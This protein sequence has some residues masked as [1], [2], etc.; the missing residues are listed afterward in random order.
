MYIVGIA[1]IV[2]GLVVTRF[3]FKLSNAINRH[4][5]GQTIGEVP[6]DPR[7][8]LVWSIGG[9]VCGWGGLA[10]IGFGIYLLLT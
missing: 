3:G 8:R 4:L 6:F 9:L 7:G 10:L 5:A 1:V 2:A